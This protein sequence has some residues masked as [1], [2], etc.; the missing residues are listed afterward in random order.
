MKAKKETKTGADGMPLSPDG[1]SHEA[2]MLDMDV[3]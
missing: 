3:M 1:L 2:K